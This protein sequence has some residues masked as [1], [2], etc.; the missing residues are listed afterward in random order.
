[1]CVPLK[2]LNRWQLCGRWGYAMERRGLFLTPAPCPSGS[3]R[4]LPC[5]SFTPESRLN[6]TTVI[7]SSPLSWWQ[8][9]TEPLR[10]A[11]KMPFSRSD[12]HCC[13]RLMAGKSHLALL[14]CKRTEKRSPSQKASPHRA[15]RVYLA[16]CANDCHTGSMLHCVLH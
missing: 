13:S 10:A 4:A 11:F 8:K 14:N 16:S 1:M 9:E 3:S 12:C 5:V 2:R 7:R 15:D 6:E